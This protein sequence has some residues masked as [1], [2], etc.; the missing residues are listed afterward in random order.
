MQDMQG[1]L[2]RLRQLRLLPVVK[3]DSPKQAVPLAK[4]LHAGGLSCAEITFRTGAAE[5]SIRRVSECV[6]E[7]YVCAG[8]V[9]TPEMAKRAVQAGAKAVISPGTNREVV[10]W[11]LEHD[12]PVL[13]GCATP[14]E[15]EQAI[16]LGLKAVKLFPAE[17]VGGGKMLKALAGPYPGM[18]FVPTGGITPEN[19]RD[20]LALSNV[21][22]CGGSWIVPE[23]ALARGDYGTIER[24]AKEAKALLL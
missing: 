17:V 23:P 9:L 1:F 15:V 19:L 5:E 3:L 16:R 24:L 11:C 7:V 6:P 8:T 18:F 22:A 14:S 13:P 10:E 20:Y 21:L 12:V 2:D 4:A